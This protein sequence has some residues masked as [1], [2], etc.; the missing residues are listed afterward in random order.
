ML[1]K[2]LDHYQLLRKW[3]QVRQDVKTEKAL[4]ESLQA[5]ARSLE[6]ELRRRGMGLY[7]DKELLN[8]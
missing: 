3:K 8:S 5:T 2:D 6:S 1:D 7:V 4:V